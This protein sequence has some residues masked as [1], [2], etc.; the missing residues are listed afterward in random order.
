MHN[1]Y[2]VDIGEPSVHLTFVMR[3]RT[4]VWLAEK[5]IAGVIDDAAFRRVVLPGSIKG[6]GLADELRGTRDALVKY[7]E[8]LDMDLLA[9]PVREAAVTEAEYTT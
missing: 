2:V 5:L 9:V 1:P 4:P 3:E 6:A 8:A 7:L